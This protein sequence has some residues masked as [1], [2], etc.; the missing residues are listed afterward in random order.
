MRVTLILTA[1]P[2]LLYLPGILVHRVLLGDGVEQF[3]GERVFALK[4]HDV[5]EG[6]LFDGENAEALFVTAARV[7]RVESVQE[8]PGLERE[9]LGGGDR[10]RREG[11]YDTERLFT[12]EVWLHTFFGL[13]Y[14]TATVTCEGESGEH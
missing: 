1:V 6:D 13:P 7:T 14:D 4:V 9:V 2:M 12:R 3:R 11:P 8:C 5:A 10:E